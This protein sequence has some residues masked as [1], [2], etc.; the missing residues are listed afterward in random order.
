MHNNGK[1]VL[2]IVKTTLLNQLSCFVKQWLI[3]LLYM[4]KDN[5]GEVYKLRP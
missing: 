1:P 4:Y 5:I 3:H 2:V